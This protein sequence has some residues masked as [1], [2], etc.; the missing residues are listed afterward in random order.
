MDLDFLTIHQIKNGD[1]QA[2]EGF[3]RKYY[4][5]ILRYCYLHI[6]DRGYAEDL[7]QETFEHFFSTLNR[8]Q[9]RGK[10]KNYLYTIAANLCRD[11]YKRSREF[12]SEDLPEQPVEPISQAE[13]KMDVYT[14]LSRLSYELREATVLYF[15]QD[16][17]QNE[18]AKILGI[19][20]TLV[21][22]RLERAK[23][24]LRV[25]LEKEEGS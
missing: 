23:E 21:Q 7:T 13:T 11:H 10:T 25:I 6:S 8:Y 3:I 15:F 9:Y 19:S 22:R 5:E 14:A 16:R 2:A 24:Q 12:P 18:I 1:A 20:Q 17:T 4:P